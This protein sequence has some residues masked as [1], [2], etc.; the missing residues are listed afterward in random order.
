MVRGPPLGAALMVMD[1]MKKMCVSFK[2]DW[3]SL[4]C[5]T[6]GEPMS[7]Y[8]CVCVCV[9]VCVGGICVCLW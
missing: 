2:I 5:G 4:L 9:C 1:G 8:V 3:P 7:L 6:A